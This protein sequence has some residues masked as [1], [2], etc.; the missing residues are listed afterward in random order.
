MASSDPQRPPLKAAAERDLRLFVA[1]HAAPAVKDA[2]EAVIGRLRGAGHV[3][4]VTRERLHL[5]L[6]FLGSTPPDKVPELRAALA[7]NANAFSRFV[8]YSSGVGA[9]PNLRKPQTVWLGV[10]DQPGRLGDLAEGV[11]RA[12]QPIGFEREMRPFRAHLTL[13]R[14]RSPRG[15]AELAHKLRAA[16]G[17]PPQRAAWPVDE[18]L[19]VQSVLRPSGP[20]YTIL[21]RFPLT[22]EE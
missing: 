18:Y 22:A 1:I 20:D 19:L 2:A 21:D 15:L 8:V 6:K 12:V 14:V 4:W 16:A 17:E 11:D 3:G 13:G 9:F 10:D 5:T 7:K